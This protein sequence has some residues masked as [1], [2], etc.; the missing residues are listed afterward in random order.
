MNLLLR[1]GQIGDLITAM[2]ASIETNSE[3]LVCESKKIFFSTNINEGYDKNV[4]TISAKLNFKIKTVSL[5]TMKTILN[6]NKVERIFFMPQSHNIFN[7][8]L[9]GLI[10]ILLRHKIE[11]LYEGTQTFFGSIKRGRSLFRERINILEKDNLTIAIVWDGKEKQKNIS[12]EQIINFSDLLFY[13]FPLATIKIIGK[14]R[15]QINYESNYFHNLSGR[16]SLEEAFDIIDNSN[17]VISVDTGLLHYAVHKNKPTIALIAHRLPLANWFPSSGPTAL[18][19]IIDSK[20]KFC[21]IS[22]CPNC[23]LNKEL[24]S[25]EVLENFKNLLSIGEI[26]N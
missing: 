7:K 23:I 25:N 12:K 13:K 10:S 21:C 2:E 11:I 9:A 6:M 18:I 5:F 16:T 15:L 19:S 20:N 17:I 14:D 22:S 26:E 24:N 8:L 1:F 4:R 3:L